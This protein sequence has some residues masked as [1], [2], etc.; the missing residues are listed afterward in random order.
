MLSNRSDQTSKINADTTGTS[1]QPEFYWIKVRPGLDCTLQQAFRLVVR[2]Y[3]PLIL[4]CA[5]G[6]M[7]SLHSLDAKLVD[8]CSSI[9][10]SQKDRYNLLIVEIDSSEELCYSSPSSVL[11][12]RGFG[13]GW[14]SL[15]RNN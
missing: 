13:P 3:A 9:E 1:C 10:L 4:R 12:G 11:D 5:H 7:L 15:A 2:T 6:G 8:L 14:V